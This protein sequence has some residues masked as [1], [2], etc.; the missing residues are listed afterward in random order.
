MQRYIQLII[1]FLP[2]F[3]LAILIYGYD[4]GSRDRSFEKVVING[5]EFTVD[6]ADTPDKREKGLSGQPGLAE[7]MAMLFIFEHPGIYGFWMKDMKFP[8][9]IIWIKNNKIIGFEKNIPPKSYPKA[10]Y[11]ELEV[12]MVLEV[13]A[14][15]VDKFNFMV[16][17][18]VYFSSMG[19][20]LP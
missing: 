11:P 15:T 18:A 16:G 2:L 4:Y 8:I 9:D 12:D 19:V 10:F 1:L 17:D 5:T 7:D 13:T 14:G 6:I 3:L 20:E